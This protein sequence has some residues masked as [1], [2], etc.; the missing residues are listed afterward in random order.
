MSPRWLVDRRGVLTQLLVGFGCTLG[1]AGVLLQPRL[2][3]AFPLE[4]Q[5]IAKV[6]VGKQPK[7][8][9]RCS[10]DATQAAISLTRDDQKKFY[11]SLGTMKPGQ[12]KEFAL[13]G[14]AGRFTYSGQMEVVI[15]GDKLES[16]LSFTTVVAPPLQVTVTQDDLDLTAQKL[17]FVAS[18]QVAFAT[19]EVI[20]TSGQ[21]LFKETK[22]VSAFAARQPITFSFAPVHAEELLRLELH[23]ED[24]DGFYR[25]V[26]LTPWSVRIPHEEVLFATNS[27]ALAREEVPKLEDS[28]ERI[29][30]ALRRYQQIRGVQLFIAGHTDTKGSP[31]HNRDLS[32]RRAQTIAAWFVAQGV[33]IRVFF[34][35]FGE[36]S[37]KVKT[38]DEVDEA[39]NRRVD[40]IL[41]VEPPPLVGATWR[42]LN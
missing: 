39:Q 21:T 20:G 31:A 27:A 32:R 8:L 29:R 3:H 41:S 13:D 14:R 16:P 33:G 6:S 12:E 10:S 40:Y 1:A 34:E 19:L 22:D 42:P 38:P 28:L 36:S 5:V 26:A 23:V 7:L 11:Y 35:G 17:R 18:R 9:V 4:V 2:A 30:E 25:A 24:Q 15:A 37:L